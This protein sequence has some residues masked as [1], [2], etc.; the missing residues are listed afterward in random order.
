LI[1]LVVERAS[2]G[3]R[4]QLTRW[5]LEVHAGVFVGSLSARVREKLWAL[6]R[7]RNRVG[8]SVLVYRAPNEQGFVVETHGDTDRTIL[9]IE[10]LQLVRRPPKPPNERTGATK[11]KKDTSRG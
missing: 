8:G 1:V 4:G 2:P 10:G 5:M 3:L 7:A 9:D 6:V 11:T